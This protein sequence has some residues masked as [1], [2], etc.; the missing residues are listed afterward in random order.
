MISKY[1][2]YSM[3]LYRIYMCKYSFLVHICQIEEPDCFPASTD[4][5]CWQLKFQLTAIPTPVCLG[6]QAK[7]GGAW[8][9]RRG[10]GKNLLVKICSIKP[11]SCQF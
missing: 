7:G 11:S 8:G 10:A 4:P 3:K 1:V 5:E 9:L 6:P 2:K